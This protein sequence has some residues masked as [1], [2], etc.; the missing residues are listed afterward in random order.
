MGAQEC[1]HCGLGTVRI[2]GCSD[3]KCARCGK[4]WEWNE[5]D[6]DETKLEKVAFWYPRLC[7]FVVKKKGRQR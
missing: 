7:R 1:P 2:A 4:H 5:H 6:D 3:I